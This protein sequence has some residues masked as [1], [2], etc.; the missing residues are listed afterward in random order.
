MPIVLSEQAWQDLKRDHDKLRLQVNRLSSGVRRHETGSFRD[1]R[2]VRFRND[3]SGEAPA[4]GV[5]RVTGAEVLQGIN[6]IKVDRPDS[7]FA[8]LYL[9]NGPNPVQSGKFGWGTWL[10]HADWVL[11]DDA[12]TPAFGE[13]WGPQ[14]ASFKLKKWRYGF[15]IWGAPTGSDTDRV[16]ASQSWVNHF[17]GQTD[18]AI[19]KGSSGTVSVYDGNNADTSINVSSVE[20]KFANVAISKKV[21]V[22]LE[23]G[24]WRLTSAEC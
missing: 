15:T 24:K 17:Y 16:L 13:S 21:S 22:T 19:N 5:L 11:Y 4:Y 18:A 23:G 9:V 6:T 1:V 10:W 20:N 3:Y 12:D 2:Q 8:R 14:N 7:S